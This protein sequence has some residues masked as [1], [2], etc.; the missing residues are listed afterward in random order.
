MK[1]VKT[2]VTTSNEFTSFTKK[3]SDGHTACTTPER[4]HLETVFTRIQ[5]NREK[6]T[7]FNHHGGTPGFNTRQCAM[8]TI[9]LHIA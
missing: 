6:K 3:P 4:T 8:S 2:V 7:H 5:C 9:F 1:R